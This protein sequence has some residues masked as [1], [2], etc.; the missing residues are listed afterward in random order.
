MDSSKP[1][2]ILGGGPAGSAAAITARLR[3]QP[4]QLIE[5]ARL[6]RHKVCGEFLSPEAVPLLDR[7]GVS[8]P[9]AAAIRRVSLHLRRAEKRFSLLE[10]ALGISRYT[11]DDRMLQRAAALGATVIASTDLQPDIVAT[12]RRASQPKGQRLFGFKSHFEGPESD[13]VDLYFF[14]G[15]YV[16]VNP[17]EGG[18]T[19]V[20]GLLPESVLAPLGFEIDEALDQFEPLRERLAPLKR[21]FDWLKVGPLVFGPQTATSSA[22][23]AGDALQFVDPFTG[24]GMLAAIETGVLAAEA[25][26][27]EYVQRVRAILAQPYYVASIMRSALSTTWVDRLL[28]LVPGRLMYQLTRPKK[29][30]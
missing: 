10:P 22:R 12:G 19:N 7:M 18:R 3:G 29:S 30:R 4:V 2:V 9:E 26:E 15:G 20:C 25:P 24:S 6:P 8:F 27:Q 1:L 11:M 21:Y 5:K 16:G 17:V 28:P 13:S 23:R 14:G